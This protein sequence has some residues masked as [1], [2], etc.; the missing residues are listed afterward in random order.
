MSVRFENNYMFNILAYLELL[1]FYLIA[2]SVTTDSCQLRFLTDK[3]TWL[4]RERH[5]G[6]V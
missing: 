2:L 3:L 4:T 6:R 1:T 5:I